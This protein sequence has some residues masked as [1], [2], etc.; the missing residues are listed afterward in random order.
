MAEDID[1]R[2]LLFPL[3]PA[4]VGEHYPPSQRTQ[5]FRAVFF[6]EATPL[7]K[8]RVLFQ[9][10]QLGRPVSRFEGVTDTNRTFFELGRREVAV[11][12]MEII[13]YQPPEDKPPAT[14]QNNQGRTAT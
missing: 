1:V 10:L 9:I 12:I 6:G 8:E 7:Q 5:D 4:A 11:Q 3:A 14:T 2:A 13:N